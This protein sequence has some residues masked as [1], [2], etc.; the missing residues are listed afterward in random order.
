MPI[1]PECGCSGDEDGVVVSTVAA[2][3]A[4]LLFEC[5]TCV[6]DMR[7]NAKALRDALAA[8]P[9]ADQPWSDIVIV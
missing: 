2:D 1:C 5:A 9:A 3:S 8:F 7:R 4:M 6:A